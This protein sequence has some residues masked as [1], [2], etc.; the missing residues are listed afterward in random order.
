MKKIILIIIVINLLT[1]GCSNSK[2][3]SKINVPIGIEAKTE[4]KGKL[5]YRNTIIKLEPYYLSTHKVKIEEW[6][7]IMP[8]KKFKGTSNAPVVVKNMKDIQEYCNKRSLREGLIPAYE[9]GKLNVY[10]NGYRLPKE[11]EIYYAYKYNIG[12]SE[13]EG[14]SLSISDTNNTMGFDDEEISINN[15]TFGESFASSG[16]ENLGEFLIEF[17]DNEKEEFIKKKQI[18]QNRIKEQIVRN[19]DFN[20]IYNGLYSEIEENRVLKDG[21]LDEIVEN[22]NTFVNTSFR[23]A[24]NLGTESESTYSIYKNQNNTFSVSEDKINGI[25]L[26][27]PEGW[28]ISKFMET[29]IKI[30]NSAKKT[31][32]SLQDYKGKIFF[33]PLYNG[34]GYLYK[35]G[36]YVYPY[37]LKK[38][39]T[40]E[41]LAD[42]LWKEIGSKEKFSNYFKTD[43]KYYFMLKSEIKN[44]EI[45]FI[46]KDN[47]LYEFSFSTINMKTEFPEELKKILIEKIFIQ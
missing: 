6:N 27:Y 32:P 25:N 19:K 13:T 24:K 2:E 14:S 3:K 41:D 31:N 36:Y 5:L 9:N 16:N 17:N 15:A 1:T 43:N 42:K 38:D 34:T 29:G 22:D 11:E 18:N 28:G 26:A 47:K 12:H 40:V 10:S 23:V 46:W 4:Y 44:E 20:N 8:D 30:R 45:F 35:F 7:A 39:D 33:L 21:G 37:S